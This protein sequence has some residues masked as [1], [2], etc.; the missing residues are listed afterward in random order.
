MKRMCVKSLLVGFLATV[1]SVLALPALATDR[2]TPQTDEFQI[3]TETLIAVTN[4]FFAAAERA[5]FETRPPA[6]QV[7][8]R[9]EVISPASLQ[10]SDPALQALTDHGA[11]QHLTGYRINWYPTSRLLGTVDYMG[12]W[13]N[14]RSLVCGYVSWDLSTP[15]APVLEGVKANYLDLSTLASASPAQVHKALLEANCA[16]GAIDVNFAFFEPAR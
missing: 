2:V 3:E 11:V 9:P 5:A 13:N 14:N 15:D 6:S 16:F 10:N 7:I 1:T 4:A 12:T 8:G